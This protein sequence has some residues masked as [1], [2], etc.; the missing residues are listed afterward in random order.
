M[1]GQLCW[2]S[3]FG[4]DGQLALHLRKQPHEAWKPYTAYRELCV[5]DYPVPGGS[6]GWATSQKLIKAGWT[7]IPTHQANQSFGDYSE[8]TLL[9]TASQ[10]RR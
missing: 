5:P 7:L 3:K 9:I 6:K 10:L 2:L 1:S 8:D 4:G